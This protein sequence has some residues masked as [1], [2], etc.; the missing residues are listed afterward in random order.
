M[1]SRPITLKIISTHSRLKAAGDVPVTQTKAHR[2]FNTQ[3]PEGGWAKPLL[4][5]F[6]GNSSISTHSRLKAAG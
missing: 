3:P 4:L 2:Y 1:S 5:V 6:T